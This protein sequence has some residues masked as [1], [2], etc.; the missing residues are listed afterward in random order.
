MGFLNFFFI[1]SIENVTKIF[2]DDIEDL[3]FNISE[4]IEQIYR[5]THQIWKYSSNIK[6]KIVDK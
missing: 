6:E 3:H 2:Y 5:K 1:L 4:N